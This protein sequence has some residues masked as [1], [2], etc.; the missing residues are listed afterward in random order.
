M[1]EDDPLEAA[2]AALL[3]AV[4][5]GR[6]E[7]EIRALLTMT[8][9]LQ[10]FFRLSRVLSSAANSELVEVPKTT[11]ETAASEPHLQEPLE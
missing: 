1:N 2:K 7:L 6:E 5:G 8:T 3:S 11:Q 9:D 4:P 10:E